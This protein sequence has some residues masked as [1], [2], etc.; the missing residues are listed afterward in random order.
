M[1]RFL[2]SLGIC[3]AFLFP[4]PSL[5][6][7]GSAFGDFVGPIPSSSS[8]AGGTSENAGDAMVANFKAGLQNMLPAQAS[9]AGGSPLGGSEEEDTMST[10]VE[11]ALILTVLSVLPALLITVTC[12]TR[13][14]IVLS[15]VRRAMSI[16]ELPPNPV[17]I[18]LALFLTAFIMGPVATNI[19]EAAYVPYQEKE[20][21]AGEASDVAWGELSVFLLANTRQ[22]EIELFTEMSGFEPNTTAN[23]GEANV[24]EGNFGTGV[25][26]AAAAAA[27]SGQTPP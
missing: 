15:F 8:S 4:A 16:N 23:P 25:G 22:S 5:A 20:L 3:L 19:Y 12:F 10:A 27:A 21:T 2:I 18:G 13:I 26:S 6:Q 11:I 7:D 24:S 1:N 9:E 17:L 14:V